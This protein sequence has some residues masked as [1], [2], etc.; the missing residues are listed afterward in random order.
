MGGTHS[1]ILGVR[2]FFFWVRELGE[3]NLGEE[4]V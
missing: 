1:Q 2:G 3:K 4:F